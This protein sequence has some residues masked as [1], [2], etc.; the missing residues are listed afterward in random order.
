MATTV[1][2]DSDLIDEVKRVTGKSTKAEAVREA[3]V[4]YV[5]SRRRKELLDLKGKITVS[6]T[7]D[8]IEASEE[9]RS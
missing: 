1:T 9:D 3:L 7:N 4:D 6:C 8:Q 2:L 5:R